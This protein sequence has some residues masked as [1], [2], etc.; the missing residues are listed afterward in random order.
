MNEQRDVQT[1][2]RA[3]RQ[4][5]FSSIGIVSIASLKVAWHGGAADA[6]AYP[7]VRGTSSA[8][9]MR[10]YGAFTIR[11]PGPGDHQRWYDPGMTTKIAISLPD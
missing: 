5:L 1:D 10:R 11:P 4:S 2:P 6:R 8:R 3:M 7:A 9:S